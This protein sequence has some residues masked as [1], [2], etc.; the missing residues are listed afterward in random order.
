MSVGAKRGATP[1][2]SDTARGETD[3]VRQPIT[4]PAADEATHGADWST[5]AGRTEALGVDSGATLVKLCARDETGRLFFD[6][7]PAPSHDRVRALLDR[8]EPERVGVTGCG[9]AGLLA[10]MGREVSRPVEFDAWGRGAGRLLRD[11]GHEPE[12]AYLLVS[13]GTGTSALRVEGD[14]VERVGGSALGGGTALGLGLALTGC[15]SHGELMRLA[16]RGERGGVDL[17]ISDIYAGDE[18]G[19]VGEATASSFGKLAQSLDRSRPNAEPVGPP[20]PEDMAASVMGLVAENIALICNAHA[21]AAGVST[22]VFGGSTLLE[23]PTIVQ[24]VDVLTRVMGHDSVMLPHCGHAG[25][26][27]AMLMSD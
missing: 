12:S 17:L 27:G 19:L 16:A 7:L 9:T 1:R 5:I 24:T 14:R 18:I 6:T 20:R 10:G 15:R 21:H 8:L 23:N 2:S 11:M 26:L 25:A 22:I 4:E 13:I 3:S